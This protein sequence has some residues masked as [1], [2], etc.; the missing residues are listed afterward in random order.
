MY[1]C[2]MQVCVYMG[3]HT[4]THMLRPEEV[5]SVCYSLETESLTE[6]IDNIM[7]KILNV[8]KI[9]LIHSVSYLTGKSLKSQHRKS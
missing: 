5:V 9:C 3:H 8:I 2:H 1:V 7:R 4:G 6:P